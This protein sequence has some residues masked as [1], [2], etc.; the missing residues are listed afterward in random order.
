MFTCVPDPHN[1][2]SVET[3]GVAPA[4]NNLNKNSRQGGV[5][6]S[7]SPIIEPIV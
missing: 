2:S 5:L 3:W 4:S 6:R 1:A 7:D